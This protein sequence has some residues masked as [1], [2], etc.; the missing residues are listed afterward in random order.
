MYTNFDFFVMKFCDFNVN[1][2]NNIL[3]ELIFQFDDNLNNDLIINE[4]V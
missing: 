1:F 2:T 4:N 3:F